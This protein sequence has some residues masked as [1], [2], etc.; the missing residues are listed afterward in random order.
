MPEIEAALPVPGNRRKAREEKKPAFAEKLS[1]IEEVEPKLE[2]KP[3]ISPEEKRRVA[4]E[5]EKA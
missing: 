2:P 4:V 5:N 1:A 3:E